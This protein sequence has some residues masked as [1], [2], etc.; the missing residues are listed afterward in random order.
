MSDTVLGLYFLGAFNSGW[1]KYLGRF[2]GLQF[3]VNLCDE[4]L[5][6]GHLHYLSLVNFIKCTSSLS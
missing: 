6:D 1:G 3:M 2:Q 4:I 5:E